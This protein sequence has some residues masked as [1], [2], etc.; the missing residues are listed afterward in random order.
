MNEESYS[1]TDVQI[2]ALN[3]LKE[4][5]NSSAANGLDIIHGDTCKTISSIFGNKGFTCGQ[6]PLEVNYKSDNN[7]TIYKDWNCYSLTI[8]DNR[9]ISS[10]IENLIMTGNKTCTGIPVGYT[11]IDENND[12][13]KKIGGFEKIRKMAIDTYNSKSVPSNYFDYNHIK[14]RGGSSTLATTYNIYIN[15]YMCGVT[16]RGNYGCAFVG[17]EDSDKMCEYYYYVMKY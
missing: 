10:D 17:K 1:L 5:Y 7:I 13:C 11:H 16:G 15:Q 6:Y 12:Y 4:A 14:E 9:I 8:E 2:N 3:E